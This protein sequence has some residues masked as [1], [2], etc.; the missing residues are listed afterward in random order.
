MI[1]NFFRNVLKNNLEKGIILSNG[2]RQ[3]A[4]VCSLIADVNFDSKNEILLGT[5]ENVIFIK[6]YLFH[7][8]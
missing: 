5:H 1:F 7:K 3:Q 8:N 4:V 6:T 2:S